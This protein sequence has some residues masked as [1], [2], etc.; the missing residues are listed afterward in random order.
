MGRLRK[1]EIERGCHIEGRFV[2]EK[3]WINRI[4][5]IDLDTCESV[6]PL[7]I[8]TKL[9]EY[10][11]VPINEGWYMDVWDLDTNNQGI[12]YRNW[13]DDIRDII[14]HYDD[15]RKWDWDHIRAYYLSL[16]NDINYLKDCNKKRV[17]LYNFYD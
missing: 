16:S 14:F 3:L 12:P 10:F 1:S 8:D 5:F 9:C 7:E 17:F 6:S 13:Y 4:K 2:R 15:K 11:K